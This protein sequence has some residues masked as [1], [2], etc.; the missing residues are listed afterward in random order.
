M[1]LLNYTTAVP[2]NRTIG[3]I[4]GVLAAHGAR[5]LMMEYGDQGRIISLAFKIEGPAGPLSIK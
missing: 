5:A 2:A 4:Q 3:Q 1:P